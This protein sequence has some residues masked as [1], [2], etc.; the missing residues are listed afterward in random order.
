MKIL[1]AIAAGAFIWMLAVTSF[2]ILENIPGFRESTTR[3]GIAVLLAMPCYAWL[4]ASRYYR[5][6]AQ[7]NG[8]FVG[9]I[10]SATALCLD[11]L[12]TVPFI[13]I[14]RGRSYDQFFTDPILWILVAE[15]LTTIFLYW[16]FSVQKKRL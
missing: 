15:N 9:L 8:L 1:K 14:P 13:E 6:V 10:A 7:P 3:Q 2:T 5:H 4:V 16:K 11:A 12:I